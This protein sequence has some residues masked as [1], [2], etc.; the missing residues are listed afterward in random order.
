MVGATNVDITNKLPKETHRM[1]TTEL[2]ALGDRFHELRDRFHELGDRFD[3]LRDRQAISEL[4]ARL[5]WMLDDK[6][7]DEASSVLAEDV[8]VQTA[9]GSAQG[10]DAVIT[11]ASRNHTVTTQHV[12]TNVVIDLHGDHA[13]ARA[14]AIITFAPDG[15]GRRLTLNDSEQPEPYVTIGEVYRSQARR[16]DDG[17]RLSRIEVARRWSTKELSGRVAVGQT[18]TTTEGSRA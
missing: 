4:I 17:W 2:I 6:R 7:F 18:P 14:N 13:E 9:G 10:R 1:S 3:E 15:P 8:S 11:Q 16:T 5:G 12:L